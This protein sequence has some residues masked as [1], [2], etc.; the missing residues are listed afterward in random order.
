MQ[1]VSNGDTLLEMK[2]EKNILQYHLQKFLLSILS[3]KLVLFVEMSSYME[4]RCHTEKSCDT[5]LVTVFLAL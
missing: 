2:N 3:V 1:I 5:V 4:M